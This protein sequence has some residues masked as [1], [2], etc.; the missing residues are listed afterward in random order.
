MGDRIKEGILLIVV[1]VN[2]VQLYSQPLG[3]WNAW[4]YDSQREL[5]QSIA[6]SLP[7]EA[8]QERPGKDYIVYFW[9]NSSKSVRGTYQEVSVA[10]PRAIRIEEV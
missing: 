4:D 2:G 5:G 8:Y 6:E 7:E 9:D 3:D 1:D 10:Y